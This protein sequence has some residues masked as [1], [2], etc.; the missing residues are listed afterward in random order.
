MA[1]ALSVVLWIAAPRGGTHLFVKEVLGDAFDSQAEHF[2]RGD[3][4]IDP[5]AIS[6]EAMIVNGK[7][8]TYFGPFPAFVRMPLNLIYGH[9]RGLWSRFSGFCAGLVALW[10]FAGLIG[11]SLRL[12]ALDRKSTRLNSSHVSE[13]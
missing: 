8:R 6:S 1:L 3:A 2:L 13:S 7:I 12:S 4:G 5:E 9:G 10:S 11:D